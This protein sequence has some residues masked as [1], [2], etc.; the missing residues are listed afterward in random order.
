[1]A[2][3]SEHTSVKV[4]RHC[5]SATLF[6]VPTYLN[7]KDHHIVVS[8][9]LFTRIFSPAVIIIICI[10]RL[11]CLCNLFVSSI[12]HQRPCEAAQ[13]KVFPGEKL[14]FFFNKLHTLEFPRFTIA[15]LQLYLFL[16]PFL[17]VRARVCACRSSLTTTI[18]VN[19]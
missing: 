8:C 19:G 1:M 15:V 18:V 9:V 7:E 11:F 17:S 3:C 2:G 12:L 4:S 16:N 13:H 5:A 6:A 10:G 14:S